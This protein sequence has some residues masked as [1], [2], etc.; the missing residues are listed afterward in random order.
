MKKSE[1]TNLQFSTI[2]TNNDDKNNNFV[3]NNF[4]DTNNYAKQNLYELKYKN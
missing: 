4:I 3:K 2:K 1:K